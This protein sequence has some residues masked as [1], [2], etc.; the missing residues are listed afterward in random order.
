MYVEKQNVYDKVKSFFEK[1][2]SDMYKC[3]IVHCNSKLLKGGI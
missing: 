2:G 1:E 3:K